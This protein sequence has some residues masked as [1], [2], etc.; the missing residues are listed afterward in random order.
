M[1]DDNVLSDVVRTLAAEKAAVSDAELGCGHTAREIR[2]GVSTP[3]PWVTYDDDCDYFD[4]FDY[5]CDAA[6]L[7]VQDCLRFGVT[8]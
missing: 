2:V 5:G 4:L 3:G 1:S 7:Y 8:P 6:R